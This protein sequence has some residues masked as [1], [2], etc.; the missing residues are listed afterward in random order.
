MSVYKQTLNNK[1]RPHSEESAFDDE[2]AREK[3]SR[4]EH[5]YR[6]DKERRAKIADRR[7]LVFSSRGLVS[8]FRHLMLDLRKLLPHHK[9]EVK[10]DERNKLYEITEICEVKSCK[11]CMFFECRKK[12]DLYMWLA[13]A[14]S[15]PSVRFHVENIHTMEELKFTGNC[16]LGSR[17]LVV[18]DKAFDSAPHLQLIKEL[19]THVFATPKG[20]PKS[21]PFVDHSINLYIADGKIWFRHYQIVSDSEKVALKAAGKLIEAEGEETGGAVAESMGKTDGS[22][23]LV[24]IGPRFCLDIVRIFA[25][26][27][28]GTTIYQNFAYASPNAVRRLQNIQKQKSYSNRIEQVAKRRKREQENVAPEDELSSFNVFQ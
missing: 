27:F 7:V 3:A 4:E 20:H 13:K 9:K 6:M 2:Y 23:E 18:F 26:S 22:T 24:E 10:F 5:E 21:K 16:L 17:P 1:K 15:G 8:R 11:S 19:F 28:G 25:G 12:K 14:P